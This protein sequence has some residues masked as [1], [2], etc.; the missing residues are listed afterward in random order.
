[1]KNPSGAL[2][3]G[4]VQNSDRSP[5]VQKAPPRAARASK[6]GV[7]PPMIGALSRLIDLAVIRRSNFP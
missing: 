5:S 6:H 3:S 2:G 7:V 4:G 1:M